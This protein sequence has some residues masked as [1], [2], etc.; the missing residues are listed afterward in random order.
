MADTF[1]ENECFFC[2]ATV[3]V[4]ASVCTH[5]GAYKGKKRESQN[6]FFAMI[7]MGLFCVILGII[8]FSQGIKNAKE[9]MWALGFLA[10]GGVLISVTIWDGAKPGWLRR[11]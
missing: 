4:G 8:G 11:N 9:F 1:N 2:K 6:G 3:P 5:C 10:G 7:I